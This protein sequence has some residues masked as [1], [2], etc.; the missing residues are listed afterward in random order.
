MKQQEFVKVLHVLKV[1]TK[2]MILSVMP[3]NK[4]AIAVKPKMTAKFVIISKLD[5]NLQIIIFLTIIVIMNVQLKLTQRIVLP[6]ILY[7]K[8]V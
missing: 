5:Q 8:L 1:H 7:A 4:I 2:E 6:M 3:V